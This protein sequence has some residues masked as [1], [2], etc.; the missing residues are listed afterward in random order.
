MIFEE[1]FH[2]LSVRKTKNKHRVYPARAKSRV[3][4]AK[5]RVYPAEIEFIRLKNRVYP[6]RNRVY[7]ASCT[8]KVQRWGRGRVYP[9]ENRVYPAPKFE[10]EFIW[11]ERVYPARGASLYGEWASLSGGIRIVVFSQQ[12]AANPKWHQKSKPYLWVYLSEF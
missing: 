10:I 3:Y 6:A 9:A 1:P 4:P 2:S 5:N 11:R 7:P 12:S 8:P